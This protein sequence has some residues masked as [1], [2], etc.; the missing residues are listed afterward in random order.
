MKIVAGYKWSVTLVVYSEI[1]SRLKI[2]NGRSQNYAEGG[3][4]Q[5]KERE[6]WDVVV[7][8]RWEKMLRFFRDR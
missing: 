8:L 1:N 3:T 2:V 4:G 6:G 5:A 7:S